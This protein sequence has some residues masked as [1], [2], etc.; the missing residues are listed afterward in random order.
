MKREKRLTKRERSALDP[1]KAQR[2]NAGGAHIH[3]IS[4]GRHIEPVEFTGD[5]PSALYLVC[6]HKSSFP[7][8]TECQVAA[9]YL[10]AEHDRTGNAVAT[11]SAWH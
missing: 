6:E 4:C 11:A 9:R 1:T 2:T 10:V 8:C 3:C 5:K 7:A